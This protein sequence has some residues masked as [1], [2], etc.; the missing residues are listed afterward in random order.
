[1]LSVPNGDELEAAFEGLDLW[2]A[3]DF[4]V[5]ETTAHC[6]YILPVTTMYERDDFALTFQQFQA[7]PFRQTTEAVVDAAGRGAHRVGH[8]RRPDEP[9]GPAHTGVRGAWRRCGRCSAP[10]GAG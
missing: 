7:T 4:Y 8:H 5:T 3:S 6:D 9:D 10:S 1:M 2:S